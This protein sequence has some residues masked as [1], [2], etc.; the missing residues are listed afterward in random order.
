MRAR[1]G[2]IAA[3]AGGAER[4]ETREEEEDEAEW[5]DD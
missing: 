3:N 2:V 1:G 5:R 4:G